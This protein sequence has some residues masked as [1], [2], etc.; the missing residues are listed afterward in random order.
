M[1]WA[2]WKNQ[3]I[4]IHWNFNFQIIFARIFGWCEWRKPSIVISYSGNHRILSWCSRVIKTALSGRRKY[5][6]TKIRAVRKSEQSSNPEKKKNRDKAKISNF[7][8][9]S[10]QKFSISKRG[11]LNKTI[12]IRQFGYAFIW[13]N[14]IRKKQ[15][16]ENL[17]IL[18][19]L[20]F[21]IRIL[22][23]ITT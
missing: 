13:K 11:E 22:P 23:Q 1:S 6:L 21:S 12:G 4:E 14:K 3:S 9:G 18:I 8:K 15:S 2:H 20:Y 5:E 10:I 7:M 17:R 16:Q 19:N